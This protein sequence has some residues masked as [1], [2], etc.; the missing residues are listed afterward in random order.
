MAYGNF[1]QTF[2]SKHIQTELKKSA[3]LVNNCNMEFEGEVKFGN[4]VKILGVG[5]P[6]ISD[7]TGKD[8]NV[9]TIEDSSVYLNISQ[10]KYFAFQVDDVDKAQ[11]KPGLMEKLMEES[12][13]AL[14]NTRESFVAL[15]AKDATLIKKPAAI[16]TPESA[17]AAIDEAMMELYQNDVAIG[18]II[19]ELPPFVWQLM[20]DKY[21]EIDT[22][23]SSMLKNGTFGH[24]NGA[25]VFMTNQL[26]QDSTNGYYAM[27]RTKKAIAFAAQI[28]KIEADRMEKSFSDMV[29]GLDVYGAK[30]VRPK[31]LCVICCKKS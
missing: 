31:E 15:Q 22:D 12:K 19:I 2:W 8:I 26:Y 10:R 9:E 16:K 7:Y 30:I 13:E 18:D 27:V 14:S 20:R 3:V 23:N 25:K 17:K 24:Y 6:T 5:K 1:K 29:K 11:S 4:S 28:Q 21:I